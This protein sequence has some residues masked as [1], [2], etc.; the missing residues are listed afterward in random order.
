MFLYYK[1]EI[2]KMYSESEISALG[3]SELY[4][5]LSNDE[6]VKLKNNIPCKILNGELI[7]S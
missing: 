1:D 4:V 3:L 5:D 2:L 6:I 7:F